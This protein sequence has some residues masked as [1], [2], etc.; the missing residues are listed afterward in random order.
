MIPVN[1]TTTEG[2]GALGGADRRLAKLE[3]VMTDVAGLAV[4]L[5]MFLTVA[6]VLGRRLFNHPV[7]GTIDI[8]E[9]W[10]VLFAFLGAAYCQRD[11]SHV[12]MDLIVLKLEG[13][14]KWALEAI[15]V[16]LAFL[17]ICVIVWKSFGHFVRAWELGDSTIDTQIQVWPS[18]LVVPIALTVLALRLALQFWGYVR[19]FRSPDAEPIAV[20]VIKTVVE[21][22]Q[23]EIEGVARRLDDVTPSAPPPPPRGRSDR[24]GR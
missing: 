23:E 6:E 1:N 8:I 2:G 13:Q 24:N 14:L 12:R 11:G 17:F 18:K 4:F 15:A 3:N 16:G 9:V 7:P 5:L 20:P 21:K 10:M 22:A 19:L